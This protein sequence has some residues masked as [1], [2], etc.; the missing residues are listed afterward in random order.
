MTIVPDRTPLQDKYPPLPDI[1]LDNLIYIE[2]AFKAAE[3][4]ELFWNL[5][6]SHL[7]ADLC[8]HLNF[9]CFCN[10]DFPQASFSD[11]LESLCDHWNSISLTLCDYVCHFTF[12]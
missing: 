9:D 11:F 7:F 8:N 2:W 12:R 4:T 1:V 3:V 5:K 10:S 6:L